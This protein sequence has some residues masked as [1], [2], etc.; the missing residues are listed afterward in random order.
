MKT[1]CERCNKVRACKT[2]VKHHAFNH[3]EFRLFCNRCRSELK[4]KRWKKV[5]EYHD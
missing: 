1:E 2:Y 4:R 5:N 3:Y